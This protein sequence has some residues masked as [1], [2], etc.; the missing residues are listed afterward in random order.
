MSGRT[1]GAYAAE[2]ASMQGSN[3]RFE[4]KTMASALDDCA[5]R[6]GFAYHEHRDA[7]DALAADD[8]DLRGCE[9]LQD[10]EQGNDGRGRKIHVT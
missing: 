5:T 9:I 8:G 1:G 2:I 4:S 3:E 10:V 6:C 7:D